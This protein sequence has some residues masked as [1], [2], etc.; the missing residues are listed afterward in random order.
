MHESLFDEIE[1]L[2]YAVGNADPGDLRTLAAAHEQA[3]R[4]AG[5]PAVARHADHA[6][7]LLERLMLDDGVDAAA[8][9]RQIAGAIDDLR[10]I[11]RGQTVGEPAPMPAPAAPTNARDLDAASGHDPAGDAA[12]RRAFLC[13]A[14]GHLSAGAAALRRLRVVPTEA[15]ADLRRALHSLKGIAA[16]LRLRDARDRA[17]E[18]EG[19]LPRPAG[20]AEPP[21]ADA[22]RVAAEALDAIARALAGLADERD[23]PEPN[24]PRAAAPLREVFARA[25][26]VARDL[27]AAEGK[28]IDVEMEAGGI[29]LDPD[30]AEAVSDALAHLARNAVDHGIEPPEQRGEKPSRGRVALRGWREAW[31]IV[32]ELSDDGRGL[33]REAILRAAADMG[34]GGAAAGDRAGAFDLIFHAGLST[35][36]L[37]GTSG[38]GVGMDIVRRRVHELGGRIEVASTPGRGATFTL[39][40]PAAVE[41][42]AAPTPACDVSAFAHP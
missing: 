27:A 35:A 41:A 33:D 22:V 21:T 3:E 23:V 1:A 4:L 29:A 9:L 11:V 6:R 26:A 20:L 36:P 24:E 39:L 25:A 34:L 12:V 28:P 31:G 42:S 16:F 10:R 30:A 13:E 7:V 5:A 37:S 18:A 38:R 8:V 2:A 40:L 17:H 15:T 32:I 19:L 14:E